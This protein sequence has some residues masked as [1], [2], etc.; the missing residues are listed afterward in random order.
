V[1]PHGDI[2]LVIK[3]MDPGVRKVYTPSEINGCHF[4]IYNA[5]ALVVG[6]IFWVEGGG[7]ERMPKSSS[8]GAHGRERT[9]AGRLG[10]R[11]AKF[12][13]HLLAQVEID[14]LVA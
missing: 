2:S 11:S 10:V 9:Q 12:F 6:E 7:Q 1:G 14:S 4:C 13:K 3:N 5:T 8:K